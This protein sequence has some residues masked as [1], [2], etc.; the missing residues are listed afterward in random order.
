MDHHQP[1]IA[2]ARDTTDDAADSPELIGLVGAAV[3]ASLLSACVDS[4]GAPTPPETRS[5]TQGVLTVTGGTAPTHYTSLEH[6]ISANSAGTPI[7]VIIDRPFTITGSTVTVPSHMTLRFQDGG[8][9]VVPPTKTVILAGPIE[10][11]PCPEHALF[12][13]GGFGPPEASCAQASNCGSVIPQHSGT[14]YYANWWSDDLGRGAPIGYPEGDQSTQ[15]DLGQQWNNMTRQ[16]AKGPGAIVRHI[17][18]A[19]N[20]K[21]ATTMDIRGFTDSQYLD[22]SASRIRIE[23]PAGGIAANFTDSSG[24]YVKSL[25][26]HSP[27]TGP[28]VGVL[29]ARSES[30][31]FSNLHFDE[32]TAVGLFQIAAVYNA[33]SKG[34][35]FVGGRLDN[36]GGRYTAFFGSFVPD[37]PHPDA[38]IM[39]QISGGPLP[40]TTNPGALVARDQVLLGTKLAGHG[41]AEAVIYIRGFSEFIANSIYSN[42]NAL[43]SVHAPQV[44]IDARD[45]TTQDIAF[46]DIYGHGNPR[47]GLKVHDYGNTESRIR[48]LTFT[49]RTFVIPFPNPNAVPPDPGGTTVEIGARWLQGAKFRVPGPLFNCSSTTVLR[50]VDVE[51]TTAGTLKLGESFTGRIAFPELSQ[52]DR[53]QTSGAFEA[54]IETTS[55][56]TAS[57]RHRHQSAMALA[58]RASVPAPDVD[59]AILWLDSATG[60][61][62]ATVTRMQ[63]GSPCTKVFTLASFSALPVCT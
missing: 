17:A 8:Q 47:L 40:R 49:T 45:H 19:G 60:D 20:R 36:I 3:G 32:L 44:V 6:A 37:A 43:D 5:I 4:G 42:S 9:L 31:P 38:A 26:L 13:V 58:E 29:L 55:R 23:M 39:D 11:P 54:E 16:M 52:L 30:G 41:L 62:K 2:A 53:S 46:D 35:V 14:K 57:P 50:E 18:V 15:A 10:A 27:N 56:A 34:N 25:F 28:H 7:T 12:K 33:A 22:F 24:L 61:L 21:L 63:G 48:N 51:M 1:E 59:E